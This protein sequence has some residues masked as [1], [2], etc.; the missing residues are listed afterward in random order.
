MKSVQVKKVAI[1][2][3]IVIL[4]IG[5]FLLLLHKSLSPQQ[6]VSR[7]FTSFNEKDENKMNFFVADGLKTATSDVEYLEY[8][9]LLSSNEATQ[10]EDYEVVRRNWEP[11]ARYVAR[12]NTSFDI[13]YA[14]NAPTTGGFSNMTYDWTFYLTKSAKNAPWTIVSYGS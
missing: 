9:H 2:I 4:I 13:K 3:V 5:I 12:V 1:G 14:D 8:V 11:D 6:T 7:F 10:P